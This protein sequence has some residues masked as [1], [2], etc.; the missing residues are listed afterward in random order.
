MTWPLDSQILGLFSKEN[1]KN[2]LQI[3]KS[4][5]E[6]VAQMIIEDLINSSLLEVGQTTEQIEE[7]V[8]RRLSYQ[9][10]LQN[11]WTHEDEDNKSISL[12]S[13]KISS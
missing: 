7:S 4:N 10:H 2:T 11:T 8:K 9:L 12:W 3:D 6:I 13:Q 5:F 1:M